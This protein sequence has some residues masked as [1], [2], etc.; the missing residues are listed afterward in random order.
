MVFNT[1][2]T[3][4][5]FSVFNKPENKIELVSWGVYIYLL[6]L[7]YTDYIK[8]TDWAKTILIIIFNIIILMMFLSIRYIHHLP[9]FFNVLP[10]FGINSVIFIILA[11]VYTFIINILPSYK[12]VNLVLLIITLINFINFTIQCNAY[13]HIILNSMLVLNTLFQ[14]SL[15][16]DQIFPNKIS[17]HIRDF[18]FF[19]KLKFVNGFSKIKKLVIRKSDS[20]KFFLIGGSSMLIILFGALIA[21]KLNLLQDASTFENF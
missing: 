20:N 10:E 16:L 6:Y 12:I 17:S 5:T 19:I 4:S 2:I 18:L 14:I 13:N 15:T 7:I 8:V 3:H 21:F 11:L 1:F 9:T